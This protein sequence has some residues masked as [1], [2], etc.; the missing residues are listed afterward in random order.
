MKTM[1]RWLRGSAD[2]LA[3]GMAAMPLGDRVERL[4][5]RGRRFAR[6]ASAASLIVI[7]GAM[8]GMVTVGS[9]SPQWVAFAQEVPVRRPS[10]PA[11]PAA[12]QPPA[13]PTAPAASR[14]PAAPVPPEPPAAPERPRVANFHEAEEQIRMVRQMEAEIRAQEAVLRQQQ[15]HLE[16][17]R[18][19][20]AARQ[21]EMQRMM[22]RAEPDRQ[23]LENE[24]ANLRAQLERLV[25]RLRER[26]A[27]PR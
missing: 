9:H 24:I 16:N 26:D 27:N 15:I 19:E 1:Q 14:A 20:L 18:L 25:Q 8:A 23:A 7:A 13:A 17:R 6:G 12:P 2:E 11:P 10:P 22:G 5:T 3:N 4:L 21:A